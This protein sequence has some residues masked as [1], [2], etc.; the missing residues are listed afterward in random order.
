VTQ[1]VGA[2]NGKG[3]DP[4]LLQVFPW[5]TGRLALRTVA[6][7]CI[8]LRGSRAMQANTFPH[9]LLVKGIAPW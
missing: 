1:G 5:L 9:H 6:L 7:A 2:S 8:G 4:F 3:S